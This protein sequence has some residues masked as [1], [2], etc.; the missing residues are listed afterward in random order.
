MA[1]DYKLEKMAMTNFDSSL[2]STTLQ[3]ELYVGQRR[4]VQRCGRA[5]WADE[6]MFSLKFKGRILRRKTLSYIGQ[7]ETR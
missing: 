1:E 6:A 2:I 4:A 5:L 3:T 7:R